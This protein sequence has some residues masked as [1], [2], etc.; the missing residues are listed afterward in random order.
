[1][2]S[3]GQFVGGGPNHVARAECLVKGWSLPRR[4][5]PAAGPCAA[6][7]LP[8]AASSPRA[9]PLR[10]RAGPGVAGRLSSSAKTLC[11]ASG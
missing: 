5:P 6:T 8:C 3:R 11:L 4:L 1:M 10:G 2:L 7:G 9:A